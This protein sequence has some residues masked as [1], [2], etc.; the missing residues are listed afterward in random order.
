M[1]MRHY[2]LVISRLVSFFVP[3]CKRFSQPPQHQWQRLTHPRRP[4]RVIP[5]LIVGIGV[6]QCAQGSS[7]DYKPGYK[8]T[9]L[10]RCEDVDFEHA[11][12]M[13]SDGFVPDFVDAE[14]WNCGKM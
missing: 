1:T 11:E 10:L 6:D 12:W 8:S 9:K 3:T 14:F 13:W 4:L 5:D 7:V 2:L